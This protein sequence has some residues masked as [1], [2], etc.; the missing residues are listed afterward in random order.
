MHE[1][2]AHFPNGAIYE[3]N[4][5]ILQGGF[6]SVIKCKRNSVSSCVFCVES[7]NRINRT[8]LII[9]Y[10]LHFTAKSN[11]FI[12]IQLQLSDYYAQINNAIMCN[13]NRYKPNKK[14]K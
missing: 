4:A 7:F 12:A 11:S 14:S 6:I 9:E 8:V 5:A 13:C 10:R 2:A 1:Q 3:R